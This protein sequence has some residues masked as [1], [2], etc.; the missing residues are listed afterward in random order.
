MVATLTRLLGVRN[1]TWV[2]DVVQAKDLKERRTHGLEYRKDCIAAEG[3][4]CSLKVFTVRNS[5]V[6]R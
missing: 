5:S 3:G 4:R 1:L 6:S 2:E